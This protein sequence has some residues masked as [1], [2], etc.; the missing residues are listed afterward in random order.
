MGMAADR[1]AIEEEAATFYL[2]VK[3]RLGNRDSLSVRETAKLYK[4][5][6][7][8]RA[9]SVEAV[10]QPRYVSTRE[11]ASMLDVSPQTIRNWVK[12]GIIRDVQTGNRKGD[13]RIPADFVDH[14]DL[15]IAG[16]PEFADP[17]AYVE[18]IREKH[19][20]LS[21]TEY[22]AMLDDEDAALK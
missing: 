14:M 9:E 2:Y 19:G 17:V 8:D 18:R 10:A 15:G 13:L 22:F 1:K 11:A 6:L 5:Y 7:A 20:K 4:E 3:A 16:N 12:G 21:D